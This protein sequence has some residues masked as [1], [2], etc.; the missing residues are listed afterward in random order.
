MLFLIEPRSVSPLRQDRTSAQ[1]VEV[2]PGK[3]VRCN[4]NFCCS[5]QPYNMPA[6]GKTHVDDSQQQDME[7]GFPADN[8][9]GRVDALPMTCHKNVPR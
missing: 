1:K 7:E 8:T 6:R 2:I 9:P 5:S 4:T 3:N